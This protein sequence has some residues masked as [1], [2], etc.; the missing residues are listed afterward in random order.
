[1]DLVS[2]FAAK[3]LGQIGKMLCP[4]TLHLDGSPVTYM[5]V[6]EHGR[7][8]ITLTMR[9][10]H[11]Y[12]PYHLLTSN[13]YPHLNHLNMTLMTLIIYDSRI[14]FYHYYFLLTIATPA[15]VIAFPLLCICI[16]MG[17]YSHSI[18]N[19]ATTSFVTHPYISGLDIF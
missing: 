10:S 7:H 4:Y 6:S 19:R 13:L 15:S 17:R 16:P 5:T 1:M 3:Q 2:M 11:L 14:A 8:T 18:P 9:G 12:Y